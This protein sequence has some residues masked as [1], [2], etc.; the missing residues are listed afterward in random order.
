MK[1]LCKYLGGS[2]A[3]GLSTPNSDQD[4]RGVFINDEV[5]HLIGLSRHDHQLC[6]DGSKDESF[7][8][9]RHALQ[10]LRNA[11]TEMVECL[12]NENWLEITPEWEQVIKFRHSL[13]SS[14]KLF[15]CLRGYMQGELK[16]ANGERTGKLGGKR[17]ESIDKFGFSPKN[18]VQYFRLA[19]AGRVYFQQGYF[20]VD[21]TKENP[22]FGKWLMMIKTRPELVSV[23]YLNE[24]AEQAERH[25]R[26]DYE[27][28]KFTSYFHEDLADKLCLKT[29]G[30]L[31]VEAYQKQLSF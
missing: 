10:L 22:D 17:K 9:F 5:K 28:R 18:F 30:P 31:I 15:G 6:Q 19:M 27:S 20:P 14:E 8:E 29:Y 16:L 13:I 3:Y 21:I 26:L 23:G 11:N 7:K 25:L 2:H 1:I 12:F 24:E 4:F